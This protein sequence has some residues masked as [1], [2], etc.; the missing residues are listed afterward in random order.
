MRLIGMGLLAFL[1][2][3]VAL[4]LS[5]SEQLRLGARVLA[6]A[7]F[8]PQLAFETR[9]DGSLG[10]RPGEAVVR[11]A[12]PDVPIILSGLPAYQGATFFMPIDARPTSGYLQI[13]ATMQVLAGVEGVLRISIGNIRRAELLLRPGEAGRS[14]RIELLEQELARERLVVS[15]SL[16]GEGPHSPC[17]GDKG[18]EVIVEIETTS[19]IFLTLD[20]PLSSPRDHVL[21]TGRE[22][23]LALPKGD[24]SPVLRAGQ[25]LA[26][27]GLVI[28]YT[29]DGVAPDV[30]VSL[31]NELGQPSVRP[32]FAWSKATAPDSPLFGLRRFHREQ[33]WRIRYDLADGQSGRLPGA[34]ELAM[35]LG[36]QTGDAPWQV[37]VTL[38][39]R[40]VGQATAKGGAFL[41]SIALPS[42]LH[43]RRNVVEIIAVAAYTPPDEC[44]RGP[45]VFAEV[46]A[47]T[48]FRAGDANLDDP[49]LSISA[50]LSGGWGLAARDLSVAEATAAT[51]LLEHL[52]VAGGGDLILR[53]VPRGAA[54]SDWSD[55]GGQVWLLY[56]GPDGQII[57]ARPS[58]YPSTIAREVLLVA[59]LRGS[60]A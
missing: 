41:R 28:R 18:L 8:G 52:P 58:D 19:A 31:A 59:D 12:N 35:E 45:D 7:A 49:F 38:N 57:V 44:N 6:E 25:K 50:A 55:A 14:L 46:R 53:A 9:A 2:A 36:R 5:N 16:Q 26:A 27:A 56:A 48:R 22:V 3:G 30:A 10:T 29:A 47:G 4:F 33:S 13:D 24:Q 40:L 20:R 32:R 17:G 60:A 51:R 43:K 54:L 34:L 23:R 21:I 42:Q 1:L 15:F 39:G 37:M 11:R